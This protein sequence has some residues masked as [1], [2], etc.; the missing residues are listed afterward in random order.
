MA[1]NFEGL[2]IPDEAK[3]ALSNQLAEMQ[4]GM[5]SRDEFEAVNNK[6]EELLAETKAAKAAQRAEA[7][8]KERAAMQAAVKSNDVEA[9]Q[10]ALEEQ[11]S[12]YNELQTSI[13]EQNDKNKEDDF[14]NKF[15]AEN[16]TNDPAA[17]LYIENESTG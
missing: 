12:K 4:K 16:V 3:E 6:K 17:R 8:E 1:L 10:K 5:V 13:T 14:I 11:K 2:E 9:L 7:E 15:L